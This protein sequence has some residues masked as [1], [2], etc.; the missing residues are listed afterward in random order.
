MRFGY[1]N[2]L[3]AKQ[4]A[5]YRKS[6]EVTAVAIPAAP[7]LAPLVEQLE[8]ALSGGKRLPTAKA[9]STFALAFC[10][11]LGVPPLRITVRLVRPEIRG[12]E[13]HGLYTFAE[14]KDAPTIEVWMRTAAQKRIVRF[15]TFLR[16][17]VHELMHHLDVALLKLDDSFHTRGFYA[18]ESSVMRQL[19]PSTRPKKV[20]TVVTPGPKQLGLFDR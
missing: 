11:Q 13:L 8:T 7:A 20:A 17:L 16:T 10:R 9:A 2:R 5:T 12:G 19:L 14:G 4:K 3:T 6:D 1:Y 15:R 18:R